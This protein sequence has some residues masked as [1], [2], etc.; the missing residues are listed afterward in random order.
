M[1]IESIQSQADIPPLPPLWQRREAWI[2][3]IVLMIIVIV[4]FVLLG[5]GKNAE[6]A[7]STVPFVAVAR[8][9][10]EDLHNEVTIPAEFRAYV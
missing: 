8:V 7:G 4:C 5:R 6:K 1:S 9:D 3:L 2:M 10:R